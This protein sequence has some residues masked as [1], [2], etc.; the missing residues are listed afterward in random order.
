MLKYT[1]VLSIALSSAAALAQ[2]PDPSVTLRKSE[3]EAIINA[4]IAKAAAS[5][6]YEHLQRQLAAPPERNPQE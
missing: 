6:A 5:R 3:L 4:E 1:L 2:Q